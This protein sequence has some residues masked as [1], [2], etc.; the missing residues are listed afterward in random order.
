MT[1]LRSTAT[2][3][4]GTASRKER[5][6]SSK[7][8]LPLCGWVTG[9]MAAI[10]PFRRSKLECVHQDIHGLLQ[11]RIAPV[12]TA[13]QEPDALPRLQG[14]PVQLD[15]A[16]VPRVRLQGEGIQRGRPPPLEEQA[17]GQ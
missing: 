12:V 4:S 13:V 5:K 9:L 10:L 3:A 7:G 15:Q 8:E 16:A 2:T 11:G 1:P 17:H 6:T 14:R